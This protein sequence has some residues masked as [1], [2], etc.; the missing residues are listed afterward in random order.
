MRLQKK[1]YRDLH[2]KLKLKR[3][4][5]SCSVHTLGDL[6]KPLL[7]VMTKCIYKFCYL[8]II[9]MQCSSKELKVNNSPKFWLFS[10]TSLSSY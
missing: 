3:L 2:V 7:V 4:Q 10:S 6:Q 8:R 5:N 9:L 1:N